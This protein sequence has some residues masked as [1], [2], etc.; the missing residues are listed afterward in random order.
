MAGDVCF[1]M[2]L[3]NVPAL[4][5]L[6][7]PQCLSKTSPFYYLLLFILRRHK[8]GWKNSLTSWQKYG[9]VATNTTKGVV[10]YHK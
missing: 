2:S 8:Q 7:I 10:T 5:W 6:E 4:S 1:C 9:F 3:Q